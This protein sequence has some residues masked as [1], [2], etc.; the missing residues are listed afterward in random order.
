[1]ER[2]KNEKGDEED[3]KEGEQPASSSST[4]Q[5]NTNNNDD[6]DDDFDFSPLR[7]FERDFSKLNSLA[8]E[9]QSDLKSLSNANHDNNNEKLAK[10]KHSFHALDEQITHTM[11][12]MDGVSVSTDKDRARRKKLIRDF[13]ALSALIQPLY[14]KQQK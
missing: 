13:G 1:M 4:K 12:K 5:N 2:E 3:E 14:Q 7:N 8:A 10:L 11:I 6:D 9:L